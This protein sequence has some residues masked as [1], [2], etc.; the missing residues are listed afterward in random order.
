MFSVIIVCVC[1]HRNAM[2]LRVHSGYLVGEHPACPL[3]LDFCSV[4]LQARVPQAWTVCCK[5]LSIFNDD[6]PCKGDLSPQDN[7]AKILKKMAKQGRAQNMYNKQKKTR[8]SHDT[9]LP[10]YCCCTSMISSCDSNLQL[11]TLEH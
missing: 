10:W 6:Q 7:F 3:G 5:M 1:S 2:S 11:R 8:R 9:P 4:P